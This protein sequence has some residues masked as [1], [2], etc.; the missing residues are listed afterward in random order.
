LTIT[1]KHK[2]K[3]KKIKLVITDV[4]GVLTDGGRHY[5]EK[6]EIMKKF[7]TVDGMG[8]NMLLRKGIKTVILTKEKS[9]IVLK[10]AKDMNVSK[11]FSG[12]IQ[13]EK[14]L[15][16]ILA[17]YH[18]KEIECVYI[19][20]D[21]NDVDVLN[22]VGFS[23]CPSDANMSALSIVDYICDKKGGHGVFREVS[24][25]ILKTQFKQVSYNPKI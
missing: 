5:N 25:L 15:K 12:S 23:A 20:D 18:V 1:I 6:G 3:L 11:V 17:K 14:T 22:K 10:W 16:S 4:D 7:H 13:K 9:K 24:D 8:V 19:G 2:N 21:I